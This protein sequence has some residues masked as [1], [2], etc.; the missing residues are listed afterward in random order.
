[1]TNPTPVQ[2]YE[3][4]TEDLEH[5]INKHSIENDSDTPDYIL[6]RFLSNVLIEWNHANYARKQQKN[7]KDNA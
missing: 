2:R 4:F 3:S 1:M 5:L 7:G 6:A